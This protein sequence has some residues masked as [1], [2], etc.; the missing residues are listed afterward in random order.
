MTGSRAAALL[1]LSL[2][3]SLAHAVDGTMGVVT[4]NRVR[5]RQGPSTG[6]AIVKELAPGTV[7]S[8]VD[9]TTDRERIDPTRE[10]AYLWYS[11][12]LDDGTAGWIYG[13]YF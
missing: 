7:A 11:I 4:A 8:I 10:F 5:L 9:A 1:L 6:H 12:E 13:Q 3:A 2:S